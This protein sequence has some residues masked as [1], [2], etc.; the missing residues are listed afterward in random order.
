MGTVLAIA[1]VIIAAPIILAVPFIGRLA[2]Y[3]GARH[4][5]NKS[6]ENKEDED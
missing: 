2:M 3:F 1:V 4:F 5:A 6:K